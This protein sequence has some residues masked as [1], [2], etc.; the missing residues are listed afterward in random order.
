MKNRRA[1]LIALAF[2]AGL[3]IGCDNP[4][5]SP[6]TPETPEK[7]PLS[8]P[9]IIERKSNFVK[10]S[11]TDANEWTPMTV[12]E[13]DS[14]ELDHGLDSN[15]RSTHKSILDLNKTN[16]YKTGIRNRTIQGAAVIADDMDDILACLS[17]ELAPASGETPILTG[18]NN[19]FNDLSAPKAGEVMILIVLDC[20]KE[21][22]VVDESVS[23]N[24]SAIEA[25]E[26]RTTEEFDAFF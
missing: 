13:M 1:L 18:F 20:I 4:A 24:E 9:W 14:N 23:L 7:K 5:N 15:L 2:A 12:E 8:S 3:L 25:R 16:A 17:L 6:E 22:I 21:A 26:N 10:P 11:L 19:I